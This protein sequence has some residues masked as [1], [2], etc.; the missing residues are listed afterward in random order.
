MSQKIVPI[1]TYLVIFVIL[2]VLTAT[3]YRVS[4]LELGR[5]N[6][7]VAL[8]IAVTKALLVALYFMHVRYSRRLTQIVIAGGVFWLGIMIALTMS[9]Y[10]TRSWLSVSL[11]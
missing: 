8:C 2:L 6:A 10:L 1:S 5:L 3:T 11:K 4:S 7:V 9:D